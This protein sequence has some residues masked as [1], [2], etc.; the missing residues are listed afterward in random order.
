MCVSSVPRANSCPSS[1]RRMRASLRSMSHPARGRSKFARQARTRRRSKSRWRPQRSRCTSTFSKAR[2]ISVAERLGVNGPR[3]VP[4]ADE[5]LNERVGDLPDPGEERVDKRA[6]TLKREHG[7]DDP[8][9]Q[10]EE[11]LA[12][13]D[14]RVN[15]PAVRDLGDD[16][17]ERRT[18]DE[19]TPPTDA[20]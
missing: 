14:A 9:A 19:A 7:A 5:M 2:F 10:A 16:R 1:T 20:D 4:M 8:E 15:D 17:L 18:S 6:A 12:E 13:S 11:M 3:E